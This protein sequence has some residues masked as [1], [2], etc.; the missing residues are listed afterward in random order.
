MGLPHGLAQAHA[1]HSFTITLTQNK[2]R[3]GAAGVSKAKL[4]G[5]FSG[6]FLLFA[7]K[8]PAVINCGQR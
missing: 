8:K 4:S 1:I 6:I 2:V 5:D 3:T 7:T